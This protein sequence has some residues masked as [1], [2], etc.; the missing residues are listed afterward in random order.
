MGS[1]KTVLPDKKFSGEDD[2]REFLRDF[3]IYVA[4]NE[5]SDE[6]AGQFLAVFLTN[7]A[8]PATRICTEESKCRGQ[9]GRFKQEGAL[10]FYNKKKN[11]DVL[12]H[13]INGLDKDLKEVLIRQDDLLERPVESILKQIS[14]L[15]EEQGVTKKVS[16]AMEM[17]VYKSKE[18][19]DLEDIVQRTVEQK[20]EEMFKKAAV[21]KK[22]GKRMGGR[23]R[24]GPEP[25]DICRAC[26]G[27][28]RW[29][30]N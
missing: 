6:K 10:A 20:V 8:P 29:T 14:T 26:K 7:D 18:H 11:E 15:E 22:G 27:Q 3:E 1:T 9:K 2:I 17:P 30:R 19:G 16:A 13:F 25:T 23:V 28:G 12:C 4:V 5:W 21:V 24:P